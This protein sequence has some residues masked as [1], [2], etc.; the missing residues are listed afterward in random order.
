M[1]KNVV[2]YMPLVHYRSCTWYQET[3]GSLCFK[4]SNLQIIKHIFVSVFSKS[5]PH[6]TAGRDGGDGRAQSCHGGLVPVP[7][8]VERPTG[9][10]R[11]PGAASGGIS[12]VGVSGMQRGSS[13]VVV[14]RVL[15]LGPDG[16]GGPERGVAELVVHGGEDLERS[17]DGL[18]QVPLPLRR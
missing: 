4:V 12:S 9:A 17:G 13:S 5:I 16:G 1:P 15:A 18:L 8:L 7:G 2:L 3:I 6:L 11:G 10:W 14:A